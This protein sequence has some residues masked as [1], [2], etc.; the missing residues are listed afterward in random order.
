[1]TVS[2]II[3]LLIA[4]GLTYLFQVYEVFEGGVLFKRSWARKRSFGLYDLE[5]DPIFK[6]GRSP[7]NPFSNF[8]FR[9]R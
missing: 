9:P 3:G 7:K 4:I 6:R 8:N 1:L 2:I 5:N